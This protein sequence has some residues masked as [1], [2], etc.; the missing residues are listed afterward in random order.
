M[1]LLS[2]LFQI[3]ATAI[4]GMGLVGAIPPIAHSSDKPP[5]RSKDASCRYDGGVP[6]FCKVRVDWG[7]NRILLWMPEGRQ[8][9][10]T[11]TY[12]G[13]CLKSGCVLTGDDWGYVGGPKRYRILHI[14][15]AQILWTGEREERPLQEINFLDY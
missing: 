5:T 15:P 3:V 7:N 9:A 4:I 13:T 11:F 10:M 2:P 8:S 1:A 12:T 6:Y 14:S